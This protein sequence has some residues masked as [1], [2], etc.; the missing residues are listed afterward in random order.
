MWISCQPTSLVSPAAGPVCQRTSLCE[1]VLPCPGSPD[2]DQRAS[3][4][5]P[6]PAN[7]STNRAPQEL[8]WRPQVEATALWL[9][10][11]LSTVQPIRT[12][13]E[14]AY[15]IVIQQLTEPTGASQPLYKS[16]LSRTGVCQPTSLLSRSSHPRR[17]QP[18]SLNASCLVLIVPTNLTIRQS[19]RLNLPANLSL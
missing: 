15:F 5:R 12:S 14:L 3:D 2:T 10:A 1:P 9:P 17:C 4:L 19:S 11:N 18:T 6:V 8:R 7:L 13:L 16:R